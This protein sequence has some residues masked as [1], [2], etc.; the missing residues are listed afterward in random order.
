MAKLHDT[1][2]DEAVIARFQEGYGAVTVGREFGIGTTTVYRILESAG[3]R[4]T[5]QIRK[6]NR[7]GVS[8]FSKETEAKIIARYSAGETMQSLADEYGCNRVTVGN[9]LKRHGAAIRPKGHSARKWD[10]AVVDEIYRRWVSGESQN[11]IGISMGL[12]QGWISSLLRRRASVTLISARMRGESHPNWKGHIKSSAGYVMRKVFSDNQFA[13]MADSGGYVMEHRLVMAESLGRS[14]TKLE[15]V[16]HING[17]KSDNRLEN[18]QLRHG[19]HGTGGSFVC[20]DCGSHNIVATHLNAKV[21][22][23]G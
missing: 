20:A 6:L 1:S 10:E 9:I 11:D 16:H 19:N 4:R 2:I 23:D 15:T 22:Q 8:K 12:S 3:I 18:L 13:D 17:D 5:G 7:T 14:L 21:G